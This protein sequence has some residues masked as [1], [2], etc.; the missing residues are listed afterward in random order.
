MAWIVAVC[1]TSRL[2]DDVVFNDGRIGVLAHA[3]G[4]GH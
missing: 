1:S 3:G 2:K 4:Q